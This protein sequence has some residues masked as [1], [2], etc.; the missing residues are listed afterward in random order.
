MTLSRPAS[1][2]VLVGAIL[3]A[4]LGP[5]GVP[6][7]AAAPEGTLT[8]AMH[9]S[10]VTR[11]LDPAEG[12]STITPYLLLYALHDGLLKPMPG[13]GSGPS[14]AQSWAMSKDMLSADFTLRPAKFH[15]GEPV[16]AEDVKFSLERYRGGAAKVLKDAVK[17]IQTPAPNRVRFVFKDPWPDFGAFFG[18][19]VASA[20]WVVPKKYFE[21]VG[22]DG[23]RKAPV[24]AGPYKFVS[25]NPGVEL[26][27]EA[28]DGYWRKQ[29]SIKRII[30]RSLPDETTRAA[31]LKSG[32]VDLAMLLSGPTAQ[33]IK[34][35]PGMRLAAPL[36][37]IFWLDFPEQWDPK[38]PWADKR[39]RL[40]AS[41][42]LDRQALNEA[43]TLGLSR[44]TGSTVPRDFEFALP[45][46]PHPYD[47][48]RAR[49]LLAEA[50]YPNGF[51]GGELTPFPPY[52]SMGETI[53]GWLQAVGIRT[54]VRSMERGTFM[55]S[56]R[57]K[58]HRG[59]VLTISGVSGNAATRLESFVTKTGAF[60]Y[61]SLPEVD[62][63]FRRQAGELDR[64]KREAI[65]HQIQ[66]VLHEQVTQ[67]PI[68]HLG[69]PIGVGPRMDD[70]MATA[71]PGFYMSPYEDL[72]LRT[73]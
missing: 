11:W 17:E 49:K 40:A 60:A 71:P 1:R 52:N 13:V 12:E 72:K 31:A 66:R 8:I 67:V 7:V 33:D 42:A 50:G 10:P 2:L 45:F 47:P 28:F 41:M 39:V 5:A 48:A 36:L 25:F 51:D 22:E 26:V 18:T 14:L 32:E 37:G 56:W 43:E 68:Y 20:G 53:Q 9:F 62:D 29:P 61:G 27:V 73:R 46:E 19:F 58:K 64:K 69:F 4:M 23:F 24:G 34:R 16:T 57:E 65:L 15:N 59:V 55:T 30:F 44:P 6:G 54:R 3:C 21:R 63:L 38:S 35:T 70:I